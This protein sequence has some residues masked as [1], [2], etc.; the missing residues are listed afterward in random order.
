MNQ[1]DSSISSLISDI[2]KMV[3]TTKKYTQSKTLKENN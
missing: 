2:D 3:A 1:A